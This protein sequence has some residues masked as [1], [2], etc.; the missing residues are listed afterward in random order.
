MQRGGGEL[1]SGKKKLQGEER[2]QEQ[3][4]REVWKGW[5]N[6]EF[7]WTDID[8]IHC[9]DFRKKKDFFNI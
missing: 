7:A 5:G 3:K 4:A 2:I 9:V 6:D 8:N 1:H